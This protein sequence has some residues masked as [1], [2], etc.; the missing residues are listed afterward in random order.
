MGS[1]KSTEMLAKTNLN[2]VRG[3]V[4]NRPLKSMEQLIDEL[5]LALVTVQDVIDRNA[6]G[7]PAEDSYIGVNLGL[8]LLH[9]QAVLTQCRLM[10][11]K[12]GET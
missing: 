6:E 1:M 3:L 4:C 2:V 9:T 10:L 12:E 7:A 8:Y 11:Q 5:E